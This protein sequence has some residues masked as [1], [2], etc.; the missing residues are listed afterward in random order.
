MTFVTGMTPGKGASIVTSAS[1]G[2]NITYIYYNSLLSE[3]GPKFSSALFNTVDV[4]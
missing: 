2:I 1:N 4:I 3:E